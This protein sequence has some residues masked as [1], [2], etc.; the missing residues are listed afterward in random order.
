M[1]ELNSRRVNFK[2]VP[3]TLTAS[4]KLERVKIS[5]RLVG[6][7]NKLH[8]NDLDRVIAGDETWVKFENSRSAM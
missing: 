3:H 6:Q 8:L 4:Q 1:E 2:W 5:G 7:L